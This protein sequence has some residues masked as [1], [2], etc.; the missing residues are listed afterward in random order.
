MRILAWNVLILKKESCE[1]DDLQYVESKKMYGNGCL[2]RVNFEIKKKKKM[3]EITDDVVTNNV[4]PGGPDEENTFT[5]HATLR[6]YRTVCLGRG[7]RRR[8]S[9]GG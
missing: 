3:D 4:A 1:N 8:R 2:E 6:R 9:I 5:V 7:R